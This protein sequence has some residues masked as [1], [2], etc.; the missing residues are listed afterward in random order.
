[1]PFRV[2]NRK[3]FSNIC[4]NYNDGN[5]SNMISSRAPQAPKYPFWQLTTYHAKII[6]Q[7]CS[8][9]KCV[10][11]SGHYIYNYMIFG[12]LT[13]IDFAMIITFSLKL[14]MR[15]RSFARVIISDD[16]RDPVD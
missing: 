12:L 11:V 6:A 5:H 14:T 9:R 3:H 10:H 1:M 15:C 4:Y 7:C 16:W 8:F 13:F 2:E